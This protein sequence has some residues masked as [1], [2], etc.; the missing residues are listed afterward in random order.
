VQLVEELAVR[1]PRLDAGCDYIGE[2]H[3]LGSHL[4]L[5]CLYV[6]VPCP[7]PEEG[8]ELSVARKDAL[9]GEAIVHQGPTG[10]VRRLCGNFFQGV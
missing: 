10:E 3:L 1:C 6:Q 8:C 2:R 4:K 9:R 7:C 5:Q